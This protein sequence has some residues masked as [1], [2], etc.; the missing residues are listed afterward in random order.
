MDS[1]GL[2][3]E[4]RGRGWPK[5]AKHVSIPRVDWVQNDTKSLHIIFVKFPAGAGAVGA[6]KV[7]PDPE[8]EP[9]PELDPPEHFTRSRSRDSSRDVVKGGPRSHGLLPERFSPH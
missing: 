1:D 2:M 9:E 8:P 5:E 6:R 7:C 4:G 3:G